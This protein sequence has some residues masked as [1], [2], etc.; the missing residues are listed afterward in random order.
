MSV[1]STA[2]LAGLPSRHFGCVVADPPWEYREGWPAWND[3]GERKPL[4]YPT[5]T[6]DDIKAM[7]VGKLLKHEAYLFLWTTSRYLEAGFE[8]CR[9]WTCAPRQVLTWCKPP[10]G[11]GPG[12]MFA[13]TTEFVIVGQRIGERS[14]AR[15]T[16][17]LGERINTSWFQ[18]PR[19]RHSEKPEAFQDT[20]MQVCP[21]PYLEL[22]A[23]RTRLGWATWG[24]EVPSKA[25]AAHQPERN[26]IG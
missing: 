10:N 8:V 9:A 19:G 25:N 18:W 1:P 12:G 7:S 16:R 14:H 17:T 24:N 23:R 4:E 11:T 3:N 21:G 26:A 2:L 5:M 13:T 15:G 22:F 6:V 20:L